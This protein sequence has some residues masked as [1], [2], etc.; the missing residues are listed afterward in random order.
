M[1]RVL[2]SGFKTLLVHSFESLEI[3]IGELSRKPDCY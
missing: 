3:G 1:L 2:R